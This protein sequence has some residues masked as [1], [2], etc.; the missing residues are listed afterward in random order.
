M[1]KQECIGIPDMILLLMIFCF[2]KI[3]IKAEIVL[4]P[5]GAYFQ[6]SNF[7]IWIDFRVLCILRY[8]CAHFVLLCQTEIQTL[9]PT[10]TLGISPECTPPVPILPMGRPVPQ[11]QL[12]LTA[13]KN[14]QLLQIQ[15]LHQVSI[16]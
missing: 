2:K 6:N 13:K 11:Q 15:G 7:L 9:S 12:H 1:I 4:S 14:E 10:T 8:R 5:G 16:F 3:K